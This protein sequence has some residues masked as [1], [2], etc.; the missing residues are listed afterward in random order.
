MEEIIKL[1]KAVFKWW[2]A[3]LACTVFMALLMAV[4]TRNIT[5]LYESSAII[6]TGITTGD[7]IVEGRIDYAITSSSYDNMVNIIT[8]RKTLTEVGLRLLAMHLGMKQDDQQIINK[9]ENYEIV[10][11]MIPPDIRKLVG[12]TDS[13]TYLNLAA[14]AET[15]SFLIGVINWPNVP[16]YSNAALSSVIPSRISDSDMIKLIY[17][18]NDPAVCQKTLEILID[19]CIRN[20]RQIKEGQT[21]KTVAYFEEQLQLAQKKLK[22]AETKEEQF[23]R[24]HGVA[25][26]SIQ[27]GFAISD[28]QQI[29]NLIQEEQKNL[30]V[31]A[32]GIR[33]IE[34][35]LGSQAQSLKRNDIML[36]RQQ[37]GR[38][39]NR[40]TNAEMNNAPASEITNLRAQC[41]QLQEELNR[42]ISETLTPSTTGK[43]ND[44]AATEY[45]NRMVAYEESQARLKALENQRNAA[46]GQFVKYQPLA[47]TMRRIQREI[48]ISL[49]EYLAALENL[50]QKRRQQ[51]DLRSFSN[52]EVIDRPNFPMTAKSKRKILIALGT[53]IGFVIPSSIFLGMA[54]FNTNIQTPLRAETITG[55]RTAGIIPN[56]RRL[57]GLK[58]SELIRDGLSDTIL[59]NMY[60]TDQKS[61]QMRILVISTR[62]GEGKTTIC[63]MLCERL[64]HKGRKPLVVTPYMDSGSWSVASY[65]VD[66]SFYRARAEDIVPVEKMSDAD[67][68]I[69]EL[70]PLI[71]NDYPVE[72]IRQFDMAFLICKANRDWVK[73]DQT[74]LDSFI[75][76]S[77]ITPQIILNDVE[78][79]VVEEILGKISKI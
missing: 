27:T 38:L 54:Y 37:L 41:N 58:D 67:I 66:Q 53:M 79:D 31:I 50:N 13:I 33:Q 21:D 1:I 29:T 61:N 15:H 23:K 28:R 51:Q 59:K 22:T 11:K 10:Q 39:F 36:K 69:I 48:D 14:L 3:I 43:T 6:Y 46:T 7:R 63:N 45:F 24:T 8:S 2:K 16:Y 78:L 20:Y 42:D 60:L 32:A 44:L 55:L 76:I 65:K 75:R 49:Q 5:K 74:A 25:D 71:M 12:P 9:P 40:L 47:D 52:I 17:T 77:G 4:L 72:L 34:G 70:P 26:L 62:P 18:C 68:L 57:E 64:L 30:T 56:S 73:A 19:V 35:Q